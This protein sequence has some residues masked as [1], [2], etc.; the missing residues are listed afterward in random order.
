MAG[1]RAWRP[2]S[3]AEATS[4][5]A[6]FVEWLRATGR[7]PAANPTDLRCWWAAEPAALLRAVA[8]FAAVDSKDG[9]LLAALADHLL[10]RDL[11]PGDTFDWRGDPADPCARAARLIGARFRPEERDP[12]ERAA[13]PRSSP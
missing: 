13:S 11:R 12:D 1:Q 3:E 4:N 5:L 6:V 2:S 10:I 9:R 8:V 7:R